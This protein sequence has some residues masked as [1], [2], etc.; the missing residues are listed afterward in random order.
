MKIHCLCLV[1]DECD[2]LAETV[3][4]ALKWADTVV[5]ADNGSIDGTAQL[6]EELAK[7]SKV[8]SLS[9]YDVPFRNILRTKMYH[10]IKRIASP[11]DW[12]CRLDADEMYIDDPRKF[13]FSLPEYIDTVWSSHFDYYFTDHELLEYENDPN[14]FL[15]L[16]IRKR[17]RYYLNAGSEPRFVKHKYPFVWNWAWPTY[18]FFSSA[19]RIR[20]AQY[21]YRS[22]EQITSRMRNRLLA[23]HQSGG[24]S[25]THE[26][27]RGMNDENDFMLRV[28][29]TDGLD[30]DD[31]GPLHERPEHLPRIYPL[32]P[33]GLPKVVWISWV[34]MQLAWHHFSGRLASMKAK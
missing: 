18:R 34:L 1:K 22:P 16:P 28:K 21:Q 11:G 5:I 26:L 8:I 2:I 23:H 30:Y 12:W 3:S 31:G 29:S 25:F 10:E 9:G 19:K 15:S 4:H 7:N 17:F 14:A 27:K 20:L 32:K 13:I 6:I 33:A 24:F